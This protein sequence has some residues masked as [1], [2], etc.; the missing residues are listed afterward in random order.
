MEKKVGTLELEQ[1]QLR[2]GAGKGQ[3]IKF[4]IPEIREKSGRMWKNS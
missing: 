3:K 2:V 4:R 1:V